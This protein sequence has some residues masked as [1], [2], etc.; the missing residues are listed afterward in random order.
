MARLNL[1]GGTY[2]SRSIIA[3]AQSCVNLY[4]EKNPQ[5]AAAPFTH[6]VTPGLTLKKAP[7]APGPA[8]GL[9]TATNG[10]LYYVSGPALYF[11][12]QNFNVTALGNLN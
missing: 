8:R 5:D 6:Y 11:V 12:D 2:L 7:L 3:S 9:Y 1:L 4:P 10:S